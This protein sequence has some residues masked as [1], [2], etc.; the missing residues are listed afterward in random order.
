MSNRSKGNLRLTRRRFTRGVDVGARQK[1]FS[2]IREAAGAGPAVVCASSDYEQLATICDRVLIFSRGRVV[3]E[4]VGSAISKEVIAEHCY[5]S[6]VRPLEHG[7][8]AGEAY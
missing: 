3:S 6:T 2:A 4:L 7:P 1:V 5:L 8:E